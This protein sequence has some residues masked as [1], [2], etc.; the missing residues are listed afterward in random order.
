M[1][2]FWQGVAA[3]GLVYAGTGQLIGWTN[4][5]VGLLVAGFALIFAPTWR[6]Q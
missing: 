1:I 3:G 5:G 4:W 2:G 6:E